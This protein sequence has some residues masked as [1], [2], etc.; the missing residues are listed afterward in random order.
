M[1][2]LHLALTR[3][4]GGGTKQIQNLCRETSIHHG[5]N[6]HL[7]TIRNGGVHKGI[8]SAYL[9]LHTVS[10]L[11][12]ID[13]RAFFRI[14][15]VC[16]NEKI[17]LIHI[18]GPTALSAAVIT[19]KIWKL[20]PF[21]FSKKTSF[22]IRKKRSTLYKYNYPKLKK[23]LCVSNATSKIAAESITDLSK[24]VTVY[25]GIDDQK[26]FS[27][28]SIRTKFNIPENKILVGTIANHIHA[29]DLETWVN[30][31]NEI[32]NVH[33]LRD[34]FFL[35]IGFFD[36]ITPKLRS[37][38]KKYNLENHVL[39]TGFLPEASAY[40]SQFD[41][42]LL[43][44]KSEGIP[45]FIHESF[46]YK[47]PVV[48]TNAGGIGEIINNGTNGFT[49]N[50]GDH[51]CLAEKLILL[52]NDSGLK[53]QFVNLSYEQVI[54]KFSTGEMAAKTVAIYKEIIDG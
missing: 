54:R 26:N 17:D 3:D 41:M 14:I 39:L 42:S 16:K 32:V 49:C 35:Q 20:P 15:S 10:M 12:N 22:P 25:H 31:V 34:F 28:E 7:L 4:F 11:A 43:T 48:S 21:V 36:E 47:V 24:L 18:H 40:I 53:T 19:D 50:I 9:K 8:E 5:C 44:S 52:Q 33:K 23:I 51:E 1:N 6:N 45:Q 46:L 27:E 29:K 2:I 38:I 37:L 30:T 13:P